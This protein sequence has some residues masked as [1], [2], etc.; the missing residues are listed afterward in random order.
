MRFKAETVVKRAGDYTWIILGGTLHVTAS[1]G[2]S[3]VSKMQT[4]GDTPEQELPVPSLTADEKGL[5]KFLTVRNFKKDRV[6]QTVVATSGDNILELLP[7]QNE[8]V[9]VS[10]PTVLGTQHI[11][12]IQN[13][14]E[15]D[16]TGLE[17][18]IVPV[19]D[20]VTVADLHRLLQ[21]TNRVTLR[22]V[23]NYYTL[24]RVYTETVLKPKRAVRLR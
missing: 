10:V 9:T 15:T 2:A 17:S 20:E 12:R 13:Y 19:N 4:S 7:Q 23:P 11:W 3:V 22:T 5:I 18:M 6:A 24:T 21:Q 16:E 14:N 1:V 8:T